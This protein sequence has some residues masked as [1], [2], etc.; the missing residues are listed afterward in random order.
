MADDRTN[1]GHRHGRRAGLLGLLAAGLVA[2]SMGAGAM[3]LAIFTSTAAVSG[4]AFTAGTVV[5]GAA[6]ATAALTATNM[7]P[8]DTVNGQIAVSN[9]GTAQLRYAMSSASTNADAKGLR[10]Q[11]TLTVKTLG[12]GCAAFDGTQLYTGAL[13]G[14][15]FGSNAAGSQ[16][17]DRTLD[18]G[19]N[20][21]LCFRATLPLATGDTFQGATT[22]ATFTFDAEQ[23]ANNP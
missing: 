12:T 2:G 19:T 21:V 16:A 13:S 20:E 1:T 10:D 9:T 8:G 17:G 3:S 15:A 23:T 11:L 6:P 18:A 4:N 5:I 14:A 7:M 22:T